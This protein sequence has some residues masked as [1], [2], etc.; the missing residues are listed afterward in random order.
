MWLE[1]G[2]FNNL[3]IKKN[4]LVLDLAC[5]D[6]FNTRNFYSFNAKKIIGIDI[7]KNAIAKAKSKNNHKNIEYYIM[8]LKKELPKGKFD[9]I[10]MDA[11]LQH[12]N[13]NETKELFKKIKIALNKNGIFSGN[14]II[15]VD[16]KN[17][18]EI[19]KMLK[20]FFKKV[21]IYETFYNDR[22]NLYFSASNKKHKNIFFKI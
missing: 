5:G 1:R 13:N 18:N 22:H 16:C 19:E 17:R 11:V 4:S 12:F 8:D 7:D 14:V 10:I 6:G 15:G 21:I 20:L 9:N 3:L 2:I